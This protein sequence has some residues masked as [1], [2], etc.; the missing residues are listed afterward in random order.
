MF[1]GVN[2]FSLSYREGKLGLFNN[3]HTMLDPVCFPTKSIWR[4]VKSMK[5]ASL[6]LYKWRMNLQDQTVVSPERN[7]VQTANTCSDSGSAQ[8]CVS[9]CVCVQDTPGHK[10]HKPSEQSYLQTYSET[11]SKDPTEASLFF[12]STWTAPGK[13]SDGSRAHASAH[14]S[15]AYRDAG[16]LAFRKREDSSKAACLRSIL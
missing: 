4:K 2:L 7:P 14:T 5:R 3:C 12:F 1:F 8:V 15:V 16:I 9:V 10:S 6:S 11:D 13:H